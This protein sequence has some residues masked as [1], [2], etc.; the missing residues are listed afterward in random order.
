METTVWM[1]LLLDIEYNYH[2]EER[3]WGLDKLIL[4]VQIQVKALKV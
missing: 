1:P 2:S 3:F 4:N